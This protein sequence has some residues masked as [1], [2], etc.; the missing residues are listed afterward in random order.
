MIPELENLVK[1]LLSK[2]ELTERSRELLIK[3]AL[4]LRTFAALT[5]K[6]VNNT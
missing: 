6:L 3:K 1:N 5:S 4:L 2:G